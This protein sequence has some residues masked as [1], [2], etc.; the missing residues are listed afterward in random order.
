MEWIGIV[1][2]GLAAIFIGVLIGVI[3]NR[4]KDGGNTFDSTSHKVFKP[5][6]ERAGTIG[7]QIA[8][9]HL[10][11]LL[12]D[13]EYLMSN[14]LLPLKN[15]HK[16]EIDCV[17]ISRKGIFCIEIKK[18]VGHIEGND[19]SEYW[20]QRYDDLFE[21]DKKHRNPVKQNEAHCEIL[22]RILRTD[23][24]VDNVV[25]FI[26]LED[27]RDIDSKY[28]FTIKS[29]PNYYYELEDEVY[30]PD[31]KTIYEKLLPYVATPEELEAHKEETRRRYGNN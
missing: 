16:T 10:R 3:K 4:K 2:F 8:I 14:I 28:V 23:Y 20:I 26:E 17:L 5:A 15:G 19:E 27:D 13:D 24:Q 7:E 22:E 30:V 29:F 1:V 25:M 21:K 6:N 11:P 12:R 18:W 9:R 31:I